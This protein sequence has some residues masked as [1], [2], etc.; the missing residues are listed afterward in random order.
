M[1]FFLTRA[2]EIYSISDEDKVNIKL[3]FYLNTSDD[4]FFFSAFAPTP[5]LINVKFSSVP[6]YTFFFN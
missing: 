6:I 5:P 1:Y 3:Y 4:K 2:F